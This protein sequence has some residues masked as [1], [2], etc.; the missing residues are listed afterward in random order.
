MG[1]TINNES[2]AEPPPSLAC[3][4]SALGSIKVDVEEQTAA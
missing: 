4:A 1:A 2:T 3:D